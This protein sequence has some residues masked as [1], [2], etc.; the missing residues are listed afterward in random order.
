MVKL[1]REVPNRRSIERV[2]DL[3]RIDEPLPSPIE[4]VFDLGV[5]AREVPDW[6]SRLMTT[7]HQEALTL[8]GPRRR[9]PGG[10]LAGTAPPARDTLE[11]V[12]DLAHGL[13]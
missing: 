6:W 12:F 3:Y 13:P 5:A 8:F 11:Q 1:L 9:A 10:T 7:A 2:F 4:S